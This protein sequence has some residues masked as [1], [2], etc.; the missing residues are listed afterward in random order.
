MPSSG[1]EDSGWEG[2]VPPGQGILTAS[3]LRD[4][5]DLNLQYIELG[6]AAE[7]VLD[8]LV[9]WTDDVRREIAA[10]EAAV[11]ARMAACPFALFRVSL[12]AGS[13]GREPDWDRVEDRGGTDSR[14]AWAVR[15]LAFRHVALFTLWRLAD[16]APLA[17]RIAFG[18][19]PGAEL[20]LNEMCPTQVARLAAHPGV[21]RARWPATAEFWSL[22]CRAARAGCVQ[23]LQW[24]HCFGICLAESDGGDPHVVEVV[25]RRDEPRR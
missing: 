17:A 6:L 4:L 2:L 1:R 5:A 13:C 7:P 24:A 15:L 16:S 25:P 22:L 21:I 19:S 12:Q 8:W 23:S 9:S 11:R 14:S 10:A 18:L 20:Q 3:V